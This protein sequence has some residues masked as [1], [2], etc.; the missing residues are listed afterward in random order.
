MSSNPLSRQLDVASSVIMTFMRGGV[1]MAT[2]PAQ[3]RP[4]YLFE[5]YEFEGCPYCRVVREALTELDLDATIYPC[6]KGGERFRPKALALGGKTQFPFLVDPNNGRQLYE[7]ADIVRYLFQ[8]YGQRELPLHWRWVELQQMGSGLA[9]LSRFGAG[10]KVRGSKA[11][12]QA[13]EL[14]SFESSPFGR[15]VRETLCELELP[16]VLRSVGRNTASDWVPPGLRRALGIKAEPETVNRKALLER[17]G[18][19]SIPYL[20]DPNTGKELSES[21]DII[22]YLERTYAL[23]DQSSWRGTATNRAD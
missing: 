13:L 9:G 3:V 12:E 7:S 1:G 23:A 21:G 10:V 18:E 20:V 11:P 14:Y 17:A 5:F 15:L 8:E 6:P 4:A 2:Q 19:I 16:Y 22:D